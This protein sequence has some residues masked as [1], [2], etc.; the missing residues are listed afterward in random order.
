MTRLQS[1][2]RN[3]LLVLALVL[4]LSLAEEAEDE[5]AEV[6]KQSVPKKNTQPKG[7]PQGGR[8]LNQYNPYTKNKDGSR[9]YTPSLNKKPH[10]EEIEEGEEAKYDK[11]NPHK[12][13]GDTKELADDQLEV[14][15]DIYDDES[16]KKPQALVGL[17]NDE[18]LRRPGTLEEKTPPNIPQ[19]FGSIDIKPFEFRIYSHNVKNGGHQT[20]VPGEQPWAKRFRKI[21]ASIKFNSQRNTVVTLQEVYKFQLND[22]MTELNRYAAEED[23]WKAYGAG[24]IDGVEIGE[25][26]PIIYKSSE[27]DLIFA[28]TLWLNDRNV[29]KGISGWDAKYPRIVSFVT[30]KHKD[31]GNYINVFNTHLDHV[32]ELSKVGSV[33]LIAERMDS[34]NEWPSFLSGD[35]NSEPGDKPYQILTDYYS[36]SSKLVTPFN[37]YGHE[38]STVTGFEGEVLL[39][40]GENIDYIF[41]PKYTVKLEDSPTCDE[42]QPKAASNKLF[43]K[44]QGWAMLHSKFGGVY[45]S[46]H[47]PIVADFS[48]AGKC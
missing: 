20:L 15:G 4:L 19:D 41:A 21:T 32:G 6:V 37:K 29:R 48:L 38:K 13:L 14:I 27:W 22:I 1:A 2:K 36:D 43:L 8:Y 12:F 35:F 44:L 26:V 31:T 16:H 11:K 24:R 45:M 30:L 7:R 25:F 40:G 42:L 5:D 39:D 28:D 47:R 18:A 33:N 34:L 23:Q 17:P 3:R 46:D 10:F 9:K